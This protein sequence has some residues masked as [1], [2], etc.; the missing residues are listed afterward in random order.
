MQSSVK[1]SETFLSVVQ[2]HFP[3]SYKERY[4]SGKW[5]CSV[6]DILEDLLHPERLSFFD[7][8]DWNN[9]DD[10]GNPTFCRDTQVEMEDQ[11][12]KVSLEFYQRIRKEYYMLARRILRI[13]QRNAAIA[14]K[15][16][17]MESNETAN[18][19]ETAI[20]KYLQKHFGDY[21]P[22]TVMLEHPFYWRKRPAL[23]DHFYC[24]DN[25]LP[26]NPNCIDFSDERGVQSN[27]EFL[28]KRKTFIKEYAKLGRLLFKEMEDNFKSCER[29]ARG[30]DEYEKRAAAVRRLQ[31]KPE[32]VEK[33][34]PKDV[35]H[36]ISEFFGRNEIDETIMYGVYAKVGV[37]RPLKPCESL[38]NF[39]RNRLERVSIDYLSRTMN[40]RYHSLEHA[41]HSISCSILSQNKSAKYFGI[42][43]YVKM[44]QVQ[45][46]YQK[47]SNLKKKQVPSSFTNKVCVDCKT[48]KPLNELVKRHDG[49]SNL[50]IVK[51]RCF[52]CDSCIAK[53]FCLLFSKKKSYCFTAEGAKWRNV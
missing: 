8:M 7:A 17:L 43:M 51:Y 24:L 9:R 32:L 3:K 31:F 28:Q 29:H 12:G 34:L 44:H 2:T 37:Y 14:R 25:L 21:I 11:F 30:I 18:A 5:I 33:R 53:E 41:V 52:S 42:A 27:K 39:V 36:L 47:W 15:G 22:K 40:A 35:V 45:G 16:I 19:I 13:F 46:K 6:S 10:Y 1:F 20:R 23:Q 38:K 49:A 26:D 48:A 50:R 4:A